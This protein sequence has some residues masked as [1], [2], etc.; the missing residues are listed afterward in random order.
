MKKLTEKQR[1]KRAENFGAFGVVALLISSILIVFVTKGLNISTDVI[2]EIPKSIFFIIGLLF[3]IGWE[4]FYLSA[5]VTS[6]KKNW[7][8]NK[9]N[10]FGIALVTNFFLW[11]VI[12]L[13]LLIF[14]GIK[15]ISAEPKYLKIVGIV[16]GVITIVILWF[17][18]NKKISDK[19]GK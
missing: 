17:V 9:G 5:T 18:S 8:E 1:D 10:T 6:E 16:I 4:L 15:T 14:K 19:L 7:L 13:I 2:K 12:Q 3:L 11:F